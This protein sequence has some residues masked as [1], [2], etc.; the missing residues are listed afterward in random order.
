MEQILS[1]IGVLDKAMYLVELL[2]RR[3]R[4]LAELVE[5]SAMSRSTVHRMLLALELHGLA[6]RD[7]DGRWH[8]GARLIGLG[9]AASD[10]F[11]LARLA[12]PVLARLRDESGESV[13]LYVRQGEHRV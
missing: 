13:Q 11:P 4:T 12:E 8:L 5:D 6:A 10:S 1:G 2:E 3:S 7:A 9:V